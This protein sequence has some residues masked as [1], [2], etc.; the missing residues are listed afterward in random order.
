MYLDKYKLQGLLVLCWFQKMFSVMHGLGAK[1]NITN[2]QN[3]TPLTLAA[4]LA[5]KTVCYRYM[6]LQDVITGASQ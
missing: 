1:L 6:Y 3:L 2:R 5:R 4:K